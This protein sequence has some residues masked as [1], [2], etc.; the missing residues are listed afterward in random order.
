[1]CSDWGYILTDK[2]KARPA[3]LGLPQGRRQFFVE[4]TGPIIVSKVE[5]GA[6]LLFRTINDNTGP[7]CIDY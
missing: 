7:E 6:E 1:M 3:W 2:W 4:K 5:Q